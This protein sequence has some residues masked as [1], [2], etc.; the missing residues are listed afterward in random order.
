MRYGPAE[1]LVSLMLELGAAHAGL[2]VADIME[3]FGVS[4]RAAFG[5]IC[6][7]EW[8]VRDCLPVCHLEPQIECT[9]TH[10]TAKQP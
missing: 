6:D 5:R 7:C 4:R 3:R 9:P 2:G 10:W 1:Q 8:Q